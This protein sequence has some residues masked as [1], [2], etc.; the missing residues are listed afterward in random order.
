[1]FLEAREVQ[2][3]INLNSGVTT[4]DAEFKNKGKKTTCKILVICPVKERL[5]HIYIF[6]LH[7]SINVCKST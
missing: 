4:L 1:M 2:C 3:C 7:I 5:E 6:S